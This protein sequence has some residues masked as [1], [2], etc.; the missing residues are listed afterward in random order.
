MSWG[1]YKELFTSYIVHHTSYI[2]CTPLFA[3][4]PIMGRFVRTKN[5]NVKIEHVIVL[6]LLN[7]KQ[8]TLQGI[9]TFKL[10]PSVSLPSETEKDFVIP[11][12]A[13]SFQYDPRATE[14]E[15]LIDSIVQHTTKIKPLASS[16]LDSFLMLGRQ[17]LNIGKPFKIDR[18][19]TL[20]KAQ[21]GELFFIPGQYTT[22]KIEAPKALKE[23]E[24]EE[25]SGLFNDYNRKPDN[26][27]KKILALVVTVVVLGLIGWAIYHFLFS[28]STNE[29]EKPV[30]QQAVPA[31]DSLVV[32]EPSNTKKDSLKTDSVVKASIYD[33]L[34]PVN[35]V[36]FKVIFKESK[37]KAEVLNSMNKLNSWGHHIIMYTSD[38]VNYKLAELFKLPLA[39]TTR[40]K[41]S[42]QRFYGNHVFVEINK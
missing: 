28:K 41:D 16:D 42:L 14:D 25:S 7:N 13:V 37:N 29:Y 8:V 20:D 24:N 17:F 4:W 33:T 11:E 27:G 5:L 6:H 22:P 31:Q 9:G 38:S 12:S 15:S 40:V 21:T 3:N 23:N 34:T 30:A 1:M 39:D 2:R 26:S 19:G 18:L 36:T 10:D 32:I 35:D